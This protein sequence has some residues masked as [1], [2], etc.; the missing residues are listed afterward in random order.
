S[1]ISHLRPKPLRE[2]KFI[3]DVHLG[4]LARY[5][6]MLGFDSLYENNYS[7]QQIIEISVKEKRIILTRDLGILKNSTVTH[8]YWLRSQNPKKQLS[9]VVNRLDLADNIKPLYRCMKCNG[10][11]EKVDKNDIINQLQPKTKKYFNEFFRCSQCKK[12]YWKGSHYEK[13]KKSL[14]TL[15]GFSLNKK[16]KNK[17]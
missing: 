15:T 10:I 12:V 13:M 5:L 17:Y 6:R 3:L 8:G 1:N 16:L 2:T 7:D 4:K 14:S 11:I 9:E